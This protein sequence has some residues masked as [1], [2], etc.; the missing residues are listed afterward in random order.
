MKTTSLWGAAIGL[1]VWLAASHEVDELLDDTLQS[2]AELLGS[3]LARTTPADPPLVSASGS[4]ERFAWQ[5]VDG[6]GRLLLRSSR[7]PDQS[8][9][10]TPQAGFSDTPQWRLYGLALGADGRMLY[11][12]QTVDERLE[13]RAEVALSAVLASLAVGLLGHVWL[14]ARVRVELEPLQRLSEQ[15]ARLSLDAPGDGPDPALGRPERQELQPVHGALQGLLQRLGARMANERA[16]SAHAA[17]ALRTPLAGID[18]QLAVALRDSPPGPLRDRLQRVR[19]AATRLQRVV[20]ALLSLF[21]TDAAPQRAVVDLAALLARLPTA[22]LAVEVEPAAHI[23]AD[24]DLLAAAL[25]NLL[26]NAQRHGAHQV[27][28]SLPAPQCL[29][30]SDDGPG[31]TPAQR[32]VLLQ[33]LARQDYESGMGL[34]LMLADRVARA[35]GGRLELPAVEQGF[36]VELD[37]RMS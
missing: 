20:A 13:A 24:P 11:A 9:Q 27:W 7:A 36:A 25:G 21:R 14:G 33:A 2:S 37:L 23:E 32:E 18:A 19:D 30:C 15:V 35:H 26:D 34:G 31:V 3:L 8:W 5:L 29:R 17:H 28:I 12:A 4:V 10:A 1:A 6:Q 16:F 22:T